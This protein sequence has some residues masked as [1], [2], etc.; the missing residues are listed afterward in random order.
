MKNLA[1]FRQ[2]E[3]H[4]LIA[5]PTGVGKS[6]TIN[7]LFDTEVAEVG[8]GVDSET[9]CIQA[10]QLD[11]NLF[12][13]DTPGLGD[14]AAC[15]L[16]YKQMI[17][18]ELSKK[19]PDGSAMIDVALIIIDG[20]HRDMG[21]SIDLINETII[22]N[23]EDRSRVLVAINQCDMADGGRGWNKKGNYPDRKLVQRL[24]EKVESVRRRIK[25][26]TG[27][28][29]QPI[30]YSALHK[31]NI[32]KLLSYIIKCTP[33][34]KRFFY[35]D[36]L[37]NDE[38]VWKYDDRNRKE[39]SPYYGKSVH[40]GYE[41][42]ANEVSDLNRSVKKMKKIYQQNTSDLQEFVTDM[43]QTYQQEVVEMLSETFGALEPVINEGSKTKISFSFK[44]TIQNVSDGISAGA[45][46]GENIGK[47]IPIIGSGTGK[48]IGGVIGGV[49][50]LLKSV[51]HR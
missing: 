43:K 9:K 23:M 47:V 24:N 34:K 5:G 35:I 4:I 8:Y 28:D 3:L 12:L 48:I 17:K 2:Q 26:S 31:Y 51:V 32:S 15:D 49:G 45:Q 10:W 44:E 41:D 13:H 37:N 21:T 39:N 27:V 19:N 25:E 30:Y 42:L 1:Q 6:S 38:Q 7:A 36:N 50:G 46:A 11:E 22:P 18:G 16:L 29:I 40:G 20:S 14:G 33:V